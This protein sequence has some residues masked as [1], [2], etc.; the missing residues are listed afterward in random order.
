MANNGG[1]SQ[2]GSTHAPMT[3]EAKG[4]WFFGVL[5]AIFLLCVFIL[6]PESLPLYKQQILA[7]ISAS[8]AAFFALFFSGTL[9]L[10]AELPLPGKWVVR[11]GS[12]FA[13]F[14]IVLFW[15]R[16]S[17]APIAAGSERN[18]KTVTSEPAKPE[19]P[20]N[21]QIPPIVKGG[22][23]IGTKYQY[24]YKKNDLECVGEYVKVS[25]VEWLEQNSAEAPSGCQIDAVIFKYTEREPEDTQYFLLY[26]EGRNL[27]AR[28]ANTT[29]GQTSPS[30]WRLVSAQT[31][32]V[33]HSVTR[34]N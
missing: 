8:L 29:V 17:A 18:D 10:N 15:W 26:D 6:G 20:K 4:S 11:G 34:V 31:W 19:P 24:R 16:S 3:N 22:A 5:F 27:F 12:A 1:T 25:A 28:L 32:N 21:Q 7:Y 13:L 33:T 9:L 23:P 2:A 30:D 14:L